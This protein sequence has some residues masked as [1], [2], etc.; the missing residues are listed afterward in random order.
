MWV[1]E[2]W[3]AGTC[4]QGEILIIYH[5]ISYRIISYRIMSCHVMSCQVMSSNVKSCQVMSCHVMSCHVMSCHVMSY[6]IVYR[7]ISY[8]IIS[9]RIVSYHHVDNKLCFWRYCSY[10]AIMLHHSTVYWPVLSYGC[11]TWSFS[12]RD[13]K[14]EGFSKQDVEEVIGDGINCVRRGFLSGDFH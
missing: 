13:S 14:Y 12:L 10:T 7:I 9:Y 6:R 1:E 5:V 11:E 2:L 4:S 8:H 3:T